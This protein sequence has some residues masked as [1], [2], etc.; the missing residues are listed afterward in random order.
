MNDPAEMEL[1]ET[2]TPYYPGYDFHTNVGVLPNDEQPEL[3]NLDDSQVPSDWT[4]NDPYNNEQALNFQEPPYF[5]D[6][7][8][9]P[10]SPEAGYSTL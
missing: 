6:P 2:E 4:L 10:L 7:S 8:A 1:N 3:S 9:A 5:M